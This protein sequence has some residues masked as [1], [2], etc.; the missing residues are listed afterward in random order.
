MMPNPIVKYH[1][2]SMVM[3]SA[4]TIATAPLAMRVHGIENV[5]GEDDPVTILNKRLA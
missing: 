3:P 1:P 2:P 4:T 5:A